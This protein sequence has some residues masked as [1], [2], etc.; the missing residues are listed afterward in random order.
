MIVKEL[1][2]WLD[3]MSPNADVKM[4]IGVKT[5]TDMDTFIT[6]REVG[7]DAICSDGITVTLIGSEV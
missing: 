1:I 7:L 5:N 6:L 4:E 2:D 3:E